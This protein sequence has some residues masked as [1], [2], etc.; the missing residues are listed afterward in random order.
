MALGVSDL[1]I[2]VEPMSSLYEQSI[3]IFVINN[4]PIIGKFGFIMHYMIR[5]VSMSLHLGFQNGHIIIK[6][7]VDLIDLRYFYYLV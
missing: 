1:V 7:N 4:P 6:V 5:L 2:H 3:C